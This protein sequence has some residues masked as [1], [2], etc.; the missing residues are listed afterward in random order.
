MLVLS[1]KSGQR[2]CIAGNIEV[3]VV[4]VQGGRVQIGI[5]APAEES[6]H[7]AEV[8]QRINQQRIQQA[9]APALPPA[10]PAPFATEAATT[11]P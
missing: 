5:N 6:I 9:P 10:A 11:C 3:T 4:S 7:R 8:Q 2:L 1:R